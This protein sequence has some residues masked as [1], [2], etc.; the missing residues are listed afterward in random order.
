MLKYIKVLHNPTPA[1][2][3]T[4]MTRLTT[5][6]ILHELEF[7]WNLENLPTSKQRQQVI[8][9]EKISVGDHH[10]IDIELYANKYTVDVTVNNVSKNQRFTQ[11]SNSFVCVLLFSVRWDTSFY[12]YLEITK[13]KNSKPK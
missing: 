5:W 8:K 2:P 1:H 10:K 12:F 11:K 4:T 13:W 9:T 6:P 7:S 3:K